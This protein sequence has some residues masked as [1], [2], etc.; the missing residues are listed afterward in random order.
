[1]SKPI[2]FLRESEPQTSN[3]FIFKNFVQLAR[4]LTSCVPRMD[5]RVY[6]RMKTCAIS[7][8]Y[9]SGSL[10]A[11][12]FSRSVLH[13]F[14]KSKSSRQPYFPLKYWPNMLQHLSISIFNN[15]P[16]FCSL[17]NGIT[18]KF[19]PELIPRK[20]SNRLVRSLASE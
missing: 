20:R 18:F 7:Q 10:G 5:R 8:S 3:W 13:Y 15:E 16:K 2:K 19:F 11:N 9:R 6:R 14:K 17:L 12:S 4:L 1:M